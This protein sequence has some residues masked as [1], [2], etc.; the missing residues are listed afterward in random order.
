MRYVPS[1]HPTASPDAATR[2]AALHSV[3]AEFE[4]TR[5]KG[6][7]QTGAP[8]KADNASIHLDGTQPGEGGSS[9]SDS[10]LEGVQLESIISNYLAVVRRELMHW[11]RSFGPAIRGKGYETE[12]DLLAEWD[13][14]IAKKAARKSARERLAR[15]LDTTVMPDGYGVEPVRLVIR[16]LMSQGREAAKNALDTWGKV[17]LA[18]AAS[19]TPNG[20]ALAVP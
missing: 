20:G 14:A 2:E 7:G 17:Q 3:M 16:T 12:G 11:F 8:E 13:L 18:A 4:A 5:A 15:G 10:D 1:E 6:N 19:G 9:G